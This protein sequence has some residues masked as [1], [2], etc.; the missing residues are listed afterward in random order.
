MSDKPTDVERREMTT[1][2]VQE[3]FG[4]KANAYRIGKMVIGVEVDSYHVTINF[5]GGRLLDKDVWCDCPGF[6]QQNF[7]KVKHKH[8]LLVLDFILDRCK[9]KSATYTI[10]GTGKN[11]R[12]KFIELEPKDA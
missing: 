7:D 4:V 1:Y 9:P 2:V 3:T 5:M 10:I 8:V 12:I 6:R 11:A